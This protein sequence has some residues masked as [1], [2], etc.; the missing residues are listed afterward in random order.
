VETVKI[1]W[2]LLAMSLVAIPAAA[3][4][5][6]SGTVVYG[7]SPDDGWAFTVSVPAGWNFDCCN[8][9]KDFDANLLVFPAGWDGQNLDHVMV[10]M[11]WP[12]E[13]ADVDSDWQADADDYFAQYPGLTSITYQA[14]VKD[15]ACLSSTYFGADSVSDYVAFCDPGADWNYRF[16]WSM[17]VRADRVD[18][19]AEDAFR[20]TVRDTM[21]LHM[22]IQASPR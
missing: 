19:A 13:R 18:T 5:I 15:A 10:L 17:S 12:T 22:H 7:G 20:E 6:G 16:A 9:A 11:V 8:R 1:S 14:Q 2:L 4:S 3:Q 21:P